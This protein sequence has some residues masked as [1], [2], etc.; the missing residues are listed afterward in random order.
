MSPL[1]IIM[2][3]MQVAIAIITGFVMGFHKPTPAK[4]RPIWS[5]F[6]PLIVMAGLSWEIANDYAGDRGAPFLRF[7]S[8]FLLGMAVTVLLLGLRERRGLNG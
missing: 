1:V 3:C 4:P 8:P 5:S 7:G 6:A 2:V